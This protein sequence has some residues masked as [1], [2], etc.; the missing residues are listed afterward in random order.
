MSN[1]THL[2]AL[3]AQRDLLVQTIGQYDAG[4]IKSITIRGRT[5]E[6]YDAGNRLMELEEMISLYENR[7]NAAAGPA[8]NKARLGRA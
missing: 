6:R 8:R 7:V 4:L 5:Y 3:I 2:A 1:A